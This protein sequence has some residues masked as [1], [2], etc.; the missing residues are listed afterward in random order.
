MTSLPPARVLVIDD[1]ASIHDDFRRI[2]APPMVDD[3]LDALASTF[4]GD[5]P[6]PTAT[7]PTSRATFELA[8]AHQG[9]DGVALARAERAAERPFAVA[10]VDMRMPPGWDGLRTIEALWEADPDVQTVICTA[11]S[12][13]SWDEITARLGHTDRLLIVRKPFDPMEILQLAHA[14][15]A[16]WQ[17]H[18]DVTQR[19]NDLDA[20]VAQEVARREAAEAELRLGQKLEAIGQLAAGVAHELNTPIQ[21]IGDNVEFLQTAIEALMAVM[22]SGQGVGEALRETAP[23]EPRLAA[24][25][26]TCR[27]ARVDFIQREVPP[28]IEQ[29]LDGVR[30][31]ASIV[32]ALREF[33]HPGVA[34]KVPVDINHALQTTL[35]VSRNEWKY[36]AEVELDL[37]PESP[38]IH[39]L[40]GELNQ[41]FLNVI[42]NAAQ[43]I[44]AVVA[45]S[46]DK[47]VIR[48]ASR[49][50][51][52]HVR[53]TIGD[54]GPGIP[55][56][57]IGRVFDPFFTTKEVG[58]GTGQGLAI[59]R[60]VVVDK[61][62]GTMAVGRSALGG[63]EFAITLPVGELFESAPVI[64]PEVC[65]S[66]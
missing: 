29:T 33:S 9:R 18:R 42:V 34:D 39:G 56:A 16:K 10:F 23:D 61:H 62:G 5:D 2:L 1:T 22:R 4:F 13:H 27:R 28:A 30:Q 11:Y 53:V 58:K 35:T 37:D 15:T 31:V 8:S 65:L 63:A 66:F 32:Q 25:E 44:G 3:G 51:G 52:A 43:A 54:S 21:Y 7:G 6:A 50:V 60:S 36:L 64:G 49:R 20:L 24:F 12:D 14:L 45:G 55:D 57:V 47:G 48:V 38:Q 26:T 40:P 19:L 17:L 46:G 59:S 41:V